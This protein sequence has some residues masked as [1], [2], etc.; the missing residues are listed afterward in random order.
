[1]SSLK[2]KDKDTDLM[3]KVVFDIKI[4]IL[5]ILTWYSSNFYLSGTMNGAVTYFG[6][7]KRDFK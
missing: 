2:R 1:M 5:P 3:I 7:N 4:D 6:S